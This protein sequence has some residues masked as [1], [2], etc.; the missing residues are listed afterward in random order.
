MPPAPQLMPN[1]S[2]SASF[3]SAAGASA[4]SLYPQ[5][6]QYT[7]NAADPFL[8]NAPMRLPNGKINLNAPPMLATPT[9]MKTAIPRL[10]SNK[11]EQLMQPGN[12]SA[13]FDFADGFD[14]SIV[15]FSGVT[16]DGILSD[17]LM[18]QTGGRDNDIGDNINGYV[19]P[20]SILTL[21]E[22]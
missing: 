14:S 3:S 17:Y 5:P 21:H 16:D 19:D 2:R 9:P 18:S 1:V 22:Y 13:S 10:P 15:N 6:G 7:Q 4:A 12:F 8:M 11:S 20:S